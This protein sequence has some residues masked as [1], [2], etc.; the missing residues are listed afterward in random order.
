MADPA[1]SLQMNGAFCRV[2]LLMF[3]GFVGSVASCLLVVV[4]RKPH[5]SGLSVKK[6]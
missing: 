5:G 3:A 6:R 1:G 2:G 4:R